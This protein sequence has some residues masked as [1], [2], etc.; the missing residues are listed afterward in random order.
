M[1]KI[2][3][4]KQGS[5]DNK[6]YRIVAIDEKRK[7]SGKAIDLLGYWQPSTNTKTLDKDKLNSWVAKG[8]VVTPA[9]KKLND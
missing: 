1:I 6:F 9:V 2:R 7:L 4:S 5:K 8:A 3:L